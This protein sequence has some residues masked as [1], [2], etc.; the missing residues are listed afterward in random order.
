VTDDVEDGVGWGIVVKGFENRGYLFGDEGWY[1]GDLLVMT[2]GTLRGLL[3]AHGNTV[4]M[5]AS[6]LRVTQ[7][8]SLKKKEAS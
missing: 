8:D 7:P 1:H 3:L 2:H 5:A 6:I 4:D